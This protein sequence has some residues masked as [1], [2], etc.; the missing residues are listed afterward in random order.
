MND[1]KIICTIIL[2][3]FFIV[4]LSAQKPPVPKEK[5]NVCN[6]ETA[7]QLVNNQVIEA[8][9]NT[10]S[11]KQIKILLRAAEFAWDLDE[12]ISRG[13]FQNAYTTA[14]RYFD[15]NGFVEKKLIKDE[16]SKIMMN[17][18][19][20]R[21]EVIRS[22]AK[23]DGKWA[24]TLTEEI[25]KEYEKNIKN[26]KENDKDKEPDDLA[27]I[28]LENV[29]GNPELSNYLFAQIMKYPLEGRWHWIL[30]G[31]A[32]KN[33][34]FADELYKKLLVN[35]RA[36]TPRKLLFLSAYPFARDRIMGVD[37]F[38]Y[39]GGYTVAFSPNIP[40]QIAFADAF[41]ARINA[42]ATVP[43]IA[44]QKDEEYRLVE[45]AYMVSA[46]EDLEPYVQNN[47]PQMLPQLS[48]AKSKANALLTAENRESMEKR[49]SY[50]K[51]VNSTIEERLATLED[52]ESEGKLTDADI[53]RIVIHLDKEEEF[54][55]A[56]T[57]LDK[58]KEEKAR[59]E[60]VNSFYHK[61]SNV[62][63]EAGNFEDAK[64]YADKVPELEFRAYLYFE[65][66]SKQSKNYN[67]S[68]DVRDNLIEVSTL[69]RKTKDS[70][71]KAQVLLGLAYMYEDI[72]HYQALG[73]ISEAVRVINKLENPDIFSAYINRQI[74][75]KGFASYASYST[76]G[77]NL[78]NAFEKISKKDF[79]LTL[80]HAQSLDDRY[81]QTLAV[82][83]VAKNCVENS[84]KELEDAKKKAEKDA[85]KAKN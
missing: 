26:R 45:P 19:D 34:P 11:V 28:A 22:I 37:K 73:E 72:E 85:K 39:G 55:K 46:L 15:E 63:L 36:E 69:A 12:P 8:K 51:E 38:Q 60:T 4:N 24:K 29:G 44:N 76:P 9:K 50:F 18:P 74:V 23:K 2:T 56:E 14:K 10:E 58:I 78:E 1:K 21:L 3:L 20:Y 80:A 49:G 65:I 68:A 35:Y 16:T 7:L 31:L 32:R 52:L 27:R 30:Q 59:E 57:W 67:D 54:E 17:E 42:L 41:F 61:R 6:S 71:G 53:I 70:V 5:L 47:F 79:D 82:L 13:Y 75:T 81:F 83:A 48:L 77:Y 66:V 62:A 33:Q 43:N 64:K 40:L 84:K 25:L